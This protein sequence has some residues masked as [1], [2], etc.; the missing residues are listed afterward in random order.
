MR[1]AEQAR[2]QLEAFDNR[3]IT[4]VEARNLPGRQLA[5]STGT[6][7]TGLLNLAPGEAQARVRQARE[8]GQQ[9]SL[10]GERLPARLPLVAASRQ[11]GTITAQHVGVIMD[12]VGKLASSEHLTADQIGHAEAFL[13]EQAESFTPPVLAGIARQLIDTLDPDGTLADQSAQRRRRNLS[14]VPLDD[15][16]HR[17]VG[18][19]DAETAALATTVLHSL[20]APKPPTGGERDG[21]TPKQPLHDALRSLL[22][23]ALRA[24]E[25]P[26]SGGLPA[27]VII[28]MTAEQ[29]ESGTGLASTSYGQKLTV[30][31]ALRLAGQACVGWVV[32]DSNGAVLN[33]GR[34]QRLA[35]RA[36]TVALI[37][38]DKGCAFPS[39]QDPPEWTEKHHITP[40][41]S[42]GRTDLN[43][44]V[45]ICDHHHDRIDTGDWQIT[46]RNGLPW[47]TPPTWIDPHQQPIRNVRP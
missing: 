5:R 29:F 17:L 1:L 12:A 14:L 18:D 9:T 37:A 22:K 8:L 6:F 47:F 11:A 23:L 15:G 20:A 41:R 2:R 34:K 31:A 36:Q 25:L 26:R 16:M 44:L 7:L 33:H 30:P 45:L 35:T 39:C 42:G 21:R 38:R 10:L 46:M 43:N 27:T 40:W 32:H 13:V 3:S 24:G 4:E 28:T 19:L